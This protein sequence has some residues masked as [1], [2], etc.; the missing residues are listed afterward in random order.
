MYIKSCQLTPCLSTHVYRLRQQFGLDEK[1]IKE[2]VRMIRN[3]RVTPK[4]GRG[5]WVRGDTTKGSGVIGEGEE[6]I[7]PV[8]A[9]CLEKGRA[10]MGEE[11]GPVSADAHTS[12]GVGVIEKE[13]KLLR[14]RVYGREGA[15]Y[16]AHSRVATCTSTC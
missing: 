5:Q 12:K 1:F 9:T 6:A 15:R 16:P 2:L 3:G 8:R 10:R 7:R 11:S 13:G 14:A 4:L